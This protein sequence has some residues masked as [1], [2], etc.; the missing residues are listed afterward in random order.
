MGGNN[1]ESALIVLIAA[2]FGLLRPE[3]WRANRTIVG[4][5]VLDTGYNFFRDEREF[6]LQVLGER[7]KPEAG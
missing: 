7:D 1:T 3:S 6:A 5:S 4:D 2:A